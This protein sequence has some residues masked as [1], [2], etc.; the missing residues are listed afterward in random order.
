MMR[1]G[2]LPP[3]SPEETAAP[4]RWMAST[5]ESIRVQESALPPAETELRR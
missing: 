5:D 3:H 1:G 2:L 4:P